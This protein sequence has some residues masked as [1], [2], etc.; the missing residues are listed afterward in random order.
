MSIKKV[1]SEQ[2]K[3]FEFNIKFKNIAEEIL[4]NTQKK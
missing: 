3:N 1:H 4:K 2:P